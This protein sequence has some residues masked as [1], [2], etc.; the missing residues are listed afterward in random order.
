MTN[1]LPDDGMILQAARQFLSILPHCNFLNMSVVSA[2][3]T[4]LT[5]ELPWSADI[6]GNRETNVIHSGVVTTLM[7][8]A[9]G[10]SVI[11]VLPRPEGC[12][13]LDLRIDHMGKPEPHKPLYAT[14]E[15]YRITRNIIFTRGTAWQDSPDKPLVNCVA[16]FMRLDKG[17]PVTKK[18]A[19]AMEQV[20]EVS[21]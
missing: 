12:P 10:I 16:A 9:C 13:T 20:W 4:G 14:A 18:D 5:L 7:D 21:P 8:T 2:D 1:P 6:V 17:F 19:E 3:R 11:T 15:A